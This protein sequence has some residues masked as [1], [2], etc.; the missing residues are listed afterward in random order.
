LCASLASLPMDR[1]ETEKSIIRTEWSSRGASPAEPMP[2]WRYGAHGYGL[3]S[4]HEPGI[5]AITAEDPQRWASTWVTAGNAVLRLAGDHV[6]AG[7]PLP[8]PRGQRRPVPAPTSA[9]P[10][11]PAYFADG[12]AGVVLDAVVRRAA[13]LS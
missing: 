13:P 1:L 7:L 6:P 2:V 4:Y 5:G 8:L 11:V 3:L 12:R 10:V 9:L